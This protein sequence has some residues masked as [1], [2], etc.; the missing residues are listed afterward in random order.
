[1]ARALLYSRRMNLHRCGVLVFVL[2]AGCGGSTQSGSS[3]DGGNAGT[4]AGGSGSN[5]GGAGGTGGDGGSN[6]GGGGGTGGREPEKHRAVATSCDHERPPGD[7]CFGACDGTTGCV[8][9]TECTAGENGRCESFRGYSECTYDVCFEDSD[10]GQ[11]GPCGC[12]TTLWSDANTCLAG[13][14]Q[15]DADCGPGGYCSPTLSTCGNY[16]G[17]TGYY[18]H[19][20]DDECTD[21]AECTGQAGQFG[22][23]Y[24]M[25]SVQVSHWICS[26]SHCVG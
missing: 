25:F 15:T 2:V 20:R 6:S 18:C 16:S 26:Y 4:N 3:A 19:T 10:C 21:D 11:G 14:C 5:S 12:E 13:N 22:P 24:C 9:D 1:M 7:P 23:G 8:A 17:V